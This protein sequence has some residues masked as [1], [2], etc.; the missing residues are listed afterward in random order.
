MVS[1]LKMYYLKV[2]ISFDSWRDADFQQVHDLLNE[3]NILHSFIKIDEENLGE[4]DKRKSSLV[5]Q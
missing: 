4:I 1:R 5:R 2:Q 3:L